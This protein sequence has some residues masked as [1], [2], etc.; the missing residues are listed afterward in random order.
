MKRLQRTG[1][2]SMAIVAGLVLGWYAAS[3]VFPAGVIAADDSHAAGAA[4]RHATDGETTTDHNL[5]H[6]ADAALASAHQLVPT[7]THGRA[8]TPTWYRGVVT[9]I[10]ILFV[11]AIVLGIASLKLKAPP[12]SDLAADHH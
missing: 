3:L 7:D 9:G 11:A 2:K 12:V 4:A 10:V 5:K 8:T 6:V 1:I